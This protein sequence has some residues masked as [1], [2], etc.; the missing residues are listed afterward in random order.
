MH[1]QS[2][3]QHKVSFFLTTLGQFLVSFN[4]FLGIYFLLLKFNRVK[5]YSL[6]E[7]LLLYGIV[8]IQFST[9]ECFARGFDSFSSMIGNGEFDRILVRPRNIIFQVLGS[10]IEFTRIGRLIQAFI[11]FVYGV[12]VGGIT[13]SFNK[14]LTVIFMI[15]GGSIIFSCVFL[16]HA[17]LCFFTTEGLEFVNILTDGVREHGKYPLDIYGKKVLAFCTFVIPYA[18]VL[19]Y[20]FLYLTGRNETPAFIFLP[21]LAILFAF[22]SYL[23]WKFGLKHYKSTGS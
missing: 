20:P 22:P 17:S 15:M 10:R 8:L 1:L 6:S 5:G 3:M 18:L 19:Y 4:T 2:S 12:K 16:L 9:A 23:F 13:W 21:L 7:I 11:M 14:I